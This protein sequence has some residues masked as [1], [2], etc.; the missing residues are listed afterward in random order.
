MREKQSDIHTYTAIYTIY[1]C[2]YVYVYIQY[3]NN[4]EFYVAKNSLRLQLLLQ[5]AILLHKYNIHIS[6]MSFYL[7]VFRSND[8]IQKKQKE[9][10]KSKHTKTKKQNI[11]I[12]NK[13][14]HIFFLFFLAS[15]IS[16]S[17]YYVKYMKINK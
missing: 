17:L 16:S 11:S 5:F 9:T 14:T 10:K 15:S 8:E 3:I 13:H 6:I 1:I 4:F 12:V 2:I 7:K